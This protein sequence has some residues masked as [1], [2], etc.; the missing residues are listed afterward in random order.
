MKSILFLL[1][2]FLLSSGMTFSQSGDYSHLLP[3]MS[4]EIIQ[5]ELAL[6]KLAMKYN[7]S[8]NSYDVPLQIESYDVDLLQNETLDGVQLFTYSAGGELRYIIEQDAA[9]NNL[10][11]ITFNWTSFGEI[12]SMI[13]EDWNGWN[14]S[15]DSRSIYTY[16]SAQ[17]LRSSTYENYNGT[18]WEFNYKYLFEYIG[19]D[20]HPSILFGSSTNDNTNWL[21]EL[22]VYYTYNGNNPTS[23]EIV[24]YDE[25]F[26]VWEQQEKWE[27]S[28]WGPEPFYPD[29][30]VNERVGDRKITDIVINKANPMEMY[31]AEFIYYSS[32]DYIT[33]IY[34]YRA[35]ITSEYD[36]SD[37]RIKFKI[38]EYN[39]TVY[40][41]TRQFIAVFD[42]CYGYQSAIS[43]DYVSPNVWTINS[44][45]TYNGT[46]VPYGA[47]CY[48]TAY[49]Y[50]SNFS[51]A[52][53]NG[54]RTQRWVISQ[55]TN[56][57]VDAIDETEVNL[58]PNPADKV[59]HITRDNGDLGSLE[60]LSIDGMTVQSQK[61]TSMEEEIQI[62][63]LPAGVYLARIVQNGNTTTK[64]FVKR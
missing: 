13:H 15:F 53:P 16:N 51:I 39:G 25:N 64:R 60:I 42:P 54:I 43:Y 44:G 37:N 48:V 3:S 33:G 41:S 28:N 47:S 7:K 18:D 63:R 17:M 29:F 11:R 32:H 1:S 4:E 2:G 61:L 38:N 58:Y 8:N 36:G 59:L 5:K 40:D 50:F 27:I 26:L 20:S 22:K 24:T 49:D 52:E 9:L 19:S 23:V 10:R 62:G 46:T 30:L 6:K 56:L 14:W 31:P 21:P 55:A 57:A 34:N 45:T 12:S 35:S